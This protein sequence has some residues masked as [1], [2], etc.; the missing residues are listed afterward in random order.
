M[1]TIRF[2]SF[3]QAAILCAVLGFSSSALITGCGTTAQKTVYRSA[4]TTSV[5][6]EAALHGY[7]AFAKAGKTTVEQ[8]RK[9]KEA[10]EKY[11]AAFAVVC[12]AGAIYAATGGTNAPAS[13]ALQQAVLNSSQTITDLVN[14]VQSFGVKL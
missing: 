6:V 7:N 5:T 2:S 9:V 14:L 4:A 3:I 13:A 12:D 11:Q 10:Y 1:K 8:N